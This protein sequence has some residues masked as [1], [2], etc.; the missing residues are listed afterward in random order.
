MSFDESA[1]VKNIAQFE[2][3]GMTQSQMAEALNRLKH[4]TPSG[5]E[6][7]Q[8]NIGNF[9]RSRASEIERIKATLDGSAPAPTV[10]PPVAAV[11]T[12]PPS[13]DGFP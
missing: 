1:V 10:A 2:K 4:L 9:R 12:P 5:L 3:Q 11:Q 6:W 7:S 8:G 13:L